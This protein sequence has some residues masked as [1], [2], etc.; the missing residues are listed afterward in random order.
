VHV[1]FAMD[2]SVCEARDLTNVQGEAD[3]IL[4]FRR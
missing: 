2:G 1:D 4:V 3:S